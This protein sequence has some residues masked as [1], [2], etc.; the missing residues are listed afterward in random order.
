MNNQPGASALC[1]GTGAGTPT[2]GTCARHPDG[3]E[4]AGMGMLGT[5]MLGMGPVAP[6]LPGLWLL[7]SLPRGFPQP[8]ASGRF[9]GARAT[10]GGI[11][12]VAGT[13][14][15]LP[16]LGSLPVLPWL[17]GAPA[18][19]PSPISP[20]KAD[21]SPA[22]RQAAHGGSPP[23]PRAAHTHPLLPAWSTPFCP[24]QQ[25]QSQPARG[26]GRSCLA[27]CD[28]ARAGL[29]QKNKSPWFLPPVASGSWLQ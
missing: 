23:P 16:L 15:A 4:G 19:A 20:G 9:M 26:R 18:S 17:S 27:G 28:P 8:L 14:R 5:G 10:S 13:D 25:H 7:S 1:M 24:P 21:A 12:A 3:W 2:L 11:H 6:S 29:C 22:A